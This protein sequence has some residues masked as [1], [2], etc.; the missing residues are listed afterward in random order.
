M[1]SVQ[2]APVTTRRPWPVV[3]LIALL[4]LLGI[5][6]LA[7]GLAM[8]SGVGGETML[9]QAW[10]DGIPL[11]DSWVFPGLVLG[12][13][14]GVGSLVV[15][16]GVIRRPVWHWLDWVE[17][18][19]G[20]HWSW[21]G[22]LIIGAGQVVWILLGAGVLARGDVAPSG[23]RLGRARPCRPADPPGRPRPPGRRSGMTGGN[24]GT[25]RTMMR[26]GRVDKAKSKE[27]T[28]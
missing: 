6:A 12:L 21:A 19:T 5:S 15:A 24:Q 22:A 3:A 28:L 9:P 14:F 27:V 18:R 8:V 25:S 4:L 23:L 26:D 11:I 16:Y 2:I 20:H 10:L 1:T 7:G 17:S 13:G